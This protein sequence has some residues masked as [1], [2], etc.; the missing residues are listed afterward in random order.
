MGCRA[1]ETRFI[2][3]IFCVAFRSILIMAEE[4]GWQV[5]SGLTAFETQ[6]LFFCL[7]GKRQATSQ[8][9]ITGRWGQEILFSAA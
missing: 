6:Q 9:R 8:V 1:I 4:S 2:E 7:F 5:G 3:S